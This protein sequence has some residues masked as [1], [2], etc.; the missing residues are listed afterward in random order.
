M[1]LY[2]AYL[3]FA[4]TRLQEDVEDDDLGKVSNFRRAVC[5]PALA[6]EQ[7]DKYGQVFSRASQEGNWNPGEVLEWSG[8]GDLPVPTGPNLFLLGGVK[9]I[10][11]E[12]SGKM[13]LAPLGARIGDY[14]C[15]IHGIEKAAVVRREHLSLRI[16]G[17]AVLAE[18]A[19]HARK[20]KEVEGKPKFGTSTV[21][22]LDDGEGLDLFVDVATAYELMG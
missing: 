3:S 22:F 8:D 15:Q 4:K 5:W 9:D 12:K 18:N 6:S 13:G 16:V 20:A 14:I 19:F 17:T 7:R 10:G 2:I 1:N 21:T 11:K